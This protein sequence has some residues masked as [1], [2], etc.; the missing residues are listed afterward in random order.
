M[1]AEGRKRVEGA[2]RGER[3]GGELEL[4]GKRLGGASP[5]TGWD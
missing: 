4:V 5:A 2:Q 1:A 3:T